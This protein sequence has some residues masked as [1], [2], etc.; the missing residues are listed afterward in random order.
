MG[1]NPVISIDPATGF[2]QGRPN[3]LG[4]YVVGICV[5]EYRNGQLL[6]T[7]L[8]DFQF[9]V[10]DC[11]PTVAAVVSASAVTGPKTFEVAR[12]GE[13]FVTILNQSQQN[14]DLKTWEW[15]V[16]LGNGTL[17]TANTWHLTVPLPAY[18]VYPVRL[19]LNRNELCR[20]TA[21][22]TLFAYPGVAAGFDYSYD[23]CTEGPVMITNTSVSGAAGGIPTT[24][25]VV[26]PLGDTLNGNISGYQFPA[27]GAYTIK[28]TVVDA[29]GCK[30][31]LVKTI[32][33]QP[34][35]APLIPAAGNMNVCLP[36]PVLFR[37][38]D[39]VNVSGCTIFWDFG[40][41]TAPV[42]SKTPVHYYEAG[43]Y[44][45]YVRITNAYNCVSTAIFPNVRVFPGVQPN[46]GFAWDVC[47]EGPVLFTDSTSTGAAGGIIGLRWIIQ[48]VGDTLYGPLGAYQFD[49]YGS[50]QVR[51]TASDADGC[52]EEYTQT[53]DWQPRVPPLIPPMKLVQVC[54]PSP[55]TFDVLEGVDLTGCTVVWN[56]GDG[57]QPV[58]DPFPVHAYL[59][60]TFSPSVVITTAIDCVSRDSFTDRVI[61]GYK[62]VADFNYTPERLSN[63]DSEVQFANLSDSTVVRWE[64]EFGTAG[65][66]GLENPQFTFLADTGLVVVT[67]FVENSQ[68]CQDTV[69]RELDVVPTLR[70]Y[71]PNIFAPLT[72]S[73]TG[74]ERFGVLGIIPGYQSFDL[75]IYNRWGAQVFASDS[76][77]ALWNGRM[78]N[79]GD[80]LPPGVYVYQ[81]NMVGP[82]SELVKV[83]GTVTLY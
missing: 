20:D 2:L 4:Q 56:F 53:V 54:H 44:N 71:I 31:E 9:N 55:V 79:S 61:T 28:Q 70:L 6:S 30:A 8:R 74:N 22:I 75:K 65:R 59:P 3:T 42:S 64:W 41:G 52:V 10:V 72:G 1:G 50:Y 36:D 7:I 49:D 37:V 57:S 33:W 60:G 13:T 40:D 67:L 69:S 58:N 29:D 66:S 27:Y 47:T 5:E 24:Q 62:P 14:A 12:C 46:F 78:Q 82:R 23:I 19:Y 17:F 45:P 34:K 26:S 81:L 35:L 68:G 38:L 32:D 15:E 21:F 25:W 11:T 63:I 77:E 76:P 51:L 43:A 16:D 18:G 83:S 80:L 48:P 39:T 73:S